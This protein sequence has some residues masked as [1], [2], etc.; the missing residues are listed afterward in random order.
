MKWTKSSRCAS[1]ACVEVMHMEA[2]DVTL[3]R[4]SAKQHV[5]LGIP[6]SI[7]QDFIEGVK[8]DEFDSVAKG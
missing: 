6:Y 8:N 3:M 1:G 5:R 7:W 2:A 4:N